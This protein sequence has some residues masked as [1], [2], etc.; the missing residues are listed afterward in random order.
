MDSFDPVMKVIGTSLV[1][2]EEGH[3]TWALDFLVLG[4]IDL[5]EDLA[6]VAGG[7]H[8]PEV[9]GEEVVLEVV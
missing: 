8:L 2:V 5:E 4:E 9:K 7:C 6:E 3:E 1:V